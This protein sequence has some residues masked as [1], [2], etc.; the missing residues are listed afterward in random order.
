M[1]LAQLGDWDTAFGH[2]RASGGDEREFREATVNA[3][4]QPPDDGSES[5]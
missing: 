3:G 4:L 1:C 2:I 5:Y